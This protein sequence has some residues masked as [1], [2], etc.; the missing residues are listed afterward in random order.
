MGCGCGGGATGRDLVTSGDYQPPPAPSP[1]A[2][3][4]LAEAE[5]PEGAKFRVTTSTEVAWF[6]DHRL[7][8]DWKGVNG[9]TLR[10]A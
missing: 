5:A 2:M 9:G 6:V 1:L 10:T 4:P 3:Q 8:F 7:A